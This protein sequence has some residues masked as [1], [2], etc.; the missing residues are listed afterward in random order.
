[1]VQL[2]RDNLLQ[3][4]LMKQ[5]HFL[6]ILVGL[7]GFASASLAAGQATGDEAMAMARKAADY[8]KSAG[9]EKAFPEF[10]AKDG[11]WH[12]RDLYVT[13]ADSRGIA[14]V[15]GANQGLVG[16][17]VLDLKDPDGKPFLRDMLAIKETGSVSYRWS[18]P[19]THVLEVKTMYVVHVD[20]Y[21]VGVGGYAK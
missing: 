12:D 16:K 19:L 17:S 20:D 13:V 7:A 8:L 9:P 3:G 14:M 5:V 6:P 2:R 21:T 1:M 11:P 10:N 15:N 18:N 4:D